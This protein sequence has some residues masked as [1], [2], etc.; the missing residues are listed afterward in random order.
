MYNTSQSSLED[1]TSFNSILH[2]YNKSIHNWWRPQ[3]EFISPHTKIW[4]LENGFNKDFCKWINNILP[5]NFSIKAQFH[6]NCNY[7][8]P[9]FI[10]TKALTENIRK[11]Y[12]QDFENFNY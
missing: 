7:D 1:W 11:F 5:I 12:H 2:T 4:K 6:H 10:K 3:H 8:Q 9:K